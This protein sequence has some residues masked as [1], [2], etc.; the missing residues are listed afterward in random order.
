MDP[1]FSVYEGEFVDSKFHGKGSLTWPDG[2]RYDGHFQG[3]RFWNLKIF[4]DFRAQFLIT[5]IQDS[6]PDGEGK[7]YD[8]DNK[9]VTKSAWK[10][11]RLISG[12]IWLIFLTEYK[13]D[14]G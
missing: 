8:V 2:S 7:Y 4:A 5:S 13:S 3:Q 6:K 12:Q 9:W 11:M 10:I 14:R 1:E